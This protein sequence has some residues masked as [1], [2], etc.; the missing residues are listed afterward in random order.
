MGRSILG[1]GVV[2]HACHATACPNRSSARWAART[3]RANG[4]R[5]RLAFGVRHSFASRLLRAKA[6]GWLS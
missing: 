5:A 1:V 3:Q 6:T 4:T 2:A